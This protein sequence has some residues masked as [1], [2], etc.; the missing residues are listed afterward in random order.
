MRGSQRG[1]GL[2]E[3]M[4]VLVIIVTVTA[5]ALPG[6]SSSI[7]RIRVATAAADFRIALAL[8]RSEAI[9]RRLR[10][11][12]LPMVRG[13]WRDGWQVVI[14]ANNNQVADAG[15]TV[16]HVG[17]SVPASVDIRARLADAR[18]AYVAF[19]PSGRPRTASSSS[20]PQ[21]GS[22]F[23]QSG[24]QRRKVV[25]GFLGRARICDP[26]RDGTAC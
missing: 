7:D 12:L 24:Q 13:D 1:W 26:D 16:L 22:V 19:D 14:D 9:R 20:V 11:D 21:F 17:P 15:D 25:I 3:T 5:A 4:I 10:V 2:I 6:I 23:F 8:T 18:A